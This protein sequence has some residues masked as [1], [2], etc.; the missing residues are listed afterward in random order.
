M[1]VAEVSGVLFSTGKGFKPQGAGCLSW[2]RSWGQKYRC[3]QTPGTKVETQEQVWGS[4]AGSISLVGGRSWCVT[5]VG[6]DSRDPVP[7]VL[8]ARCSPPPALLSGSDPARPNLLQ[9][10]QTRACAQLPCRSDHAE[11]ACLILF[12]ELKT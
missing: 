6:C 1:P 4:K 10:Y 8:A 5:V 7:L 3:Q 11:A 2:S 12:G 9:Q